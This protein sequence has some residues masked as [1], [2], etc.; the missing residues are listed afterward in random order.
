MR[1]FWEIASWSL[2]KVHRHSEMSTVS[3]SKAM[4]EAVRTYEPPVFFKEA[5]RRCIP[6]G[7]RLHTRRRNNLKS[8]MYVCIHASM[9]VCMYVCVCMYACMY[10]CS[11]FKD[12]FSVTKTLQ[13]QWNVDTW[14][15]IRKGFRRKRSRTS[16]K[17]RSRHSSGGTAESHE[18][19][20]PV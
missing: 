6:E 17:L 4:T 12:S 11:L 14:M 5:T 19:P 16:T 10:V 7:C 13:R 1:A 20:Q 18:N 2:I 8:H 15:T 3:I 9:H